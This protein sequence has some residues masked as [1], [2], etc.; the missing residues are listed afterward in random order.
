MKVI[1]MHTLLALLVLALGCGA[2]DEG[3]APAGDGTTAGPADVPGYALCGASFSP[4]GAIDLAT[5]VTA[6]ETYADRPLVVRATVNEVCQVSGCW[7]MLD[8]GA[9]ATGDDA[10][11]DDATS[12]DATGGEAT[13]D[14]GAGGPEG[15]AAVAADEVIVQFKDYGFFVPKDCAGREVLVAGE[16]QRVE[17]SVEELRHLAE[18]AGRSEA[19]ISAITEPEMAW[20]IEATGVLIRQGEA[21]SGS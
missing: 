15:G 17:R 18:D 1:V 8:A 10:T 16:L 6:P 11:G 9:G 21:T 13:G 14:G 7:M 5:I 20:R 3:D 4:E 2:G 19:E 12:G